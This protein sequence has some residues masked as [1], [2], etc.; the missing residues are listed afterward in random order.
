M[1]SLNLLHASDVNKGLGLVVSEVTTV[2]F[3]GLLKGQCSCGE[4][5]CLKHVYCLSLNIKVF[6]LQSF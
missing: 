5:T 1:D 4:D 3:S 6:K 2:S